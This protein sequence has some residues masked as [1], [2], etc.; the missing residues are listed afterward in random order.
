MRIVV[1]VGTQTLS[2][3]GDCLNRPRMI[4]LVRQIAHLHAKDHELLLVSSGAIFAGRKVLGTPR[5]DVAHQVDA[6]HP[7]R[8][9]DI[10][11]KQTLAAIG[12]VR[13]MA[14]YEQ[15]FGLYDTRIAQALLTR[16]D[17]ADR[18]RYLN[19]RNTMLSLL[20]LGV[21]PVINENDVVG[22]EE[23]RIGDNDNLSALVANL[24]E[25]DLLVMLTDLPGL[26]T[27][28]P[29]VDPGAELIREVAFIDDDIRR[30][31][32][33]SGSSV[34]TGG[35][36]TKI[37]AAEMA[38]R[39]GT[40]AVIAAGDEPDV[41][42]RLV[43]GEPLGTRFLPVVSRVESR[44]RWILAEPPR[45]EISV[46]EGAAEAL[47][48]RGKSLLAVGVVG[49]EG[50][51]ERGQTVRLS[52]PNG[53]EVARGITHYNSE[54][55]AAIRGLRSEEIAETLDAEYGPTVVHRDDMVLVS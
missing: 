3:G 21:V 16:A 6:L 23:I 48:R 9:K 51:F 40:Q 14:I 26:F 47:L 32:G 28:D 8:R 30:L 4:D 2:A 18:E 54:D 11:F 10:P 29:R 38:T 52:D 41:L 33:G 45:G 12:Q 34:G 5:A 55:L 1:K 39:S 42:L 43:S 25:A 36:A 53:R 50:N 13:L 27:A 20:R 22:V 31:A 49:V 44:K 19:A 15:L 24:V 7:P 35:A 17:L 46:D 37:A